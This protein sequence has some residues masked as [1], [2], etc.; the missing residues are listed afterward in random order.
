MN[1]EEKEQDVEEVKSGVPSSNISEVMKSNFGTYANY[2]IKQ[3]AVPDVRDGLKPVHRRLLY[4]AY[5][6]PARCNAKHVKSAEITAACMGKYH[7]HG[8]A[9]G[10]MVRMS[11]EFAMR[12]PTFDGQGNMGTVEDP[13]AA[14]RYTECRLSKLGQEIFFTE[15]NEDIVPWKSNYAENRKEP[16]VLPAELPHLLMNGTEGIAVGLATSILPFNANELI[17]CIIAEIDENYL[18][19]NSDVPYRSFHG[20]DFPT[21]GIMAKNK[22]SLDSVWKEGRGS[23]RLRGT[24]HFETD[25]TTGKKRIII[26]ETPWMM[27]R[28]NWL[29][30]TAQLIEGK[31]EDGKKGIEGVIDM[32][33]ESSEKSGTR[34]VIELANRYDPQVVLNL[35]YQKTNLQNSYSCNIV[36]I[37]DNKPKKYGVCKCLLRWLEFRRECVTNSLKREQRLLN[38]RLE[39][40]AG[41]LKVHVNI[42]DVIKTIRSSEN[43]KEAIQKKFG[44]TDRQAEAIVRMQLG[45]LRNID[46]KELQTEQK[47]INDRNAIITRTLKDKKLIDV[48]I[49]ERLTWWKNQLNPRRTQIISEFGKIEMLDTIIKEDAVMS[50]NNQ[51]EIK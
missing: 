36:V 47:T 27:D 38:E 37:D 35:L 9:Y 50:V 5:E 51:D 39:L 21:G 26:T 48:L 32:R 42:E 44:F 20:P 6:L 11:Q 2:V 24:A 22:E 25:E 4:A 13:P 29:S 10:T 16:C 18:T 43:A 12:Y 8:D 49:K 30:E 7:P 46:Q 17:D 33:D 28:S 23:F 41:F 19:K 45:R 31:D 34:I 3:R 1:K 15:L 14:S 40:I